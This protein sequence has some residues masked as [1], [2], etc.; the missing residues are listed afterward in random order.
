MLR[1]HEKGRNSAIGAG[2]Y[3]SHG[4]LHREVSAAYLW[5]IVALI[6]IQ[7]AV[8]PQVTKAQPEGTARWAVLDFNNTA[9]YGGPE[10]GR[11][12]ADALVVQ[13]AVRHR[14]EV[15]SRAEIDSGMKA[16]GL[17]FPL[18]TL[19]LLQL[20]ASISVRAIV[21][22]SVL[23]VRHDQRGRASVD[24]VVRVVDIV[25]GEMVNGA[26]VG[27]SSVARPGV[28]D[29]VLVNEALRKAAFAVVRQF[30]RFDL[31]IG[32]VLSNEGTTKVLINK[33]SRDGYKTGLNLIVLRQGRTTG[34]LRIASCDHDSSVAVVTDQGIG[35]RPEDRTHAVFVL[36]RQK[37]E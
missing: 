25:S 8:F 14:A 28:D 15:A 1:I 35:I 29:D 17:T 32:T 22:G 5:S 34:K 11:A 24:L 33:G 2:P 13:L 37:G 16:Q 4:S 6:T 12:A 23:A 10:L 31:P 20:G 30:D 9:S 18:D 3:Y 7:I 26:L 27:A 19:D 36:P 21:T